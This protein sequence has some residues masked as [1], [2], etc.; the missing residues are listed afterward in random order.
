VAPQT[1]ER[2]KRLVIASGVEIS[3]KTA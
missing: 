2:L 1:A 3:T